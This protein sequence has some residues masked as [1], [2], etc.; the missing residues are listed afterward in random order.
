MRY[1][2]PVC[3]KTIRAQHGITEVAVTPNIAVKP[4]YQKIVVFGGLIFL[5]LPN[6][7]FIAGW[8]QPIVAIPLMLIILCAS[9]TVMRD[10]QCRHVL[11][12]TRDRRALIFTMLGALL[13]VEMI[14]FHGH[15]PQMCDFYVR[16][17]IYNTLIQC[18]WPLFSSW[19]KY[20]VYYAAYWLP[21]ALASKLMPGINPAHFLF[22]WT[23]LGMFLSFGLFF[24]RLRARVWCFFLISLLAGSLF[25]IYLGILWRSGFDGRWSTLEHIMRFFCTGILFNGWAVQIM[26]TFN[27]AVP[28]ILAASLLWSR[29]VPKR[30]MPFV[31]SLSVICSPLGSIGLFT[32][33]LIT[34]SPWRYRGK[35][36][37]LLCRCF[38]LWTGVILLCF[39]TWYYSMSTSSK[40]SCTIPLFGSGRNLLYTCA[41]YLCSLGAFLL[42]FF[43]ML[44]YGRTKRLCRSSLFYALVCLSLFISLIR[45]GYLY[46]NELMLKA[47]LFVILFLALLFSKWW[48]YAGKWGK[49]FFL[50][51]MLLYSFLFL[52]RMRYFVT[53]W[54]LDQ[55]K[56]KLHV[57][58]PWEG[59]LN[60]PEHWVNNSFWGECPQ[61]ITPL[62][63]EEGESATM[64]LAP[65]ATGRKCSEMGT[66]K[67]GD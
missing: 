67:Q 16:N 10:V 51:L 12:T 52:K 2:R 29:L 59:H 34:M 5:L 24:M 13:T 25:E 33:M 26:Q 50:S 56:I 7:L 9:Y 60:H 40:V 6:L 37:L 49:V 66:E 36:L 8:M 14:S 61:G 15:I 41:I 44:R 32:L 35:E 22:L 23:F 39:V 45:V 21:P 19:N 54:S 27:H 64:L 65:V 57:M 4:F 47:S 55:D 63:K 38:S 18:D 42:P 46:N 3:M 58:D 17:P 43:L 11:C 48:Q 28:M 1:P 30:H 31:A 53:E 62:Y 20:F